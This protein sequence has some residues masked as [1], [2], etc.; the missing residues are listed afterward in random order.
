MSTRQ[1]KVN[2]LLQREIADFLAREGFEGIVGIV[3]ITG[4]AVT[5]DLEHAK[6]FFSVVGQEAT[7]V[8]EILKR[9]IYEIQGMLLKKLRMKKVPRVAFYPDYS[10]DYAQRIGALIKDLHK[11]ERQ[12]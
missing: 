1:E 7:E 11:D 8:L 9:H 5:A 12:E 6:V 4:A 3:T 10:G 2:A